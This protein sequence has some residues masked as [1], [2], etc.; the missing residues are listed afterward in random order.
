MNGLPSTKA[1]C[2]H[3]I[4]NKVLKV[5]A[6]TI[7]RSLTQIFNN[8]VPTSCFPF[9]WKMARLLS[10]YEKGPRGLPENYRSISGRSK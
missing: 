3:K 7:A 1:I 10:V 8:S 9:N 2:L 5:G 6:P 4:P